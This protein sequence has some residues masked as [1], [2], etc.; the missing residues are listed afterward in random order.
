MSALALRIAPIQLLV[1]PAVA[2]SLL[3]VAA[4]LGP[5]AVVPLLGVLGLAVLL[6]APMQW[7]AIGLLGLALVADN[8]GERPADGRWRSPLLPLGE[9]LYDN[10]HKLTGIG[11]LRVS[12]L[13][14][15]IALLLLIVVM[16]KARRDAIDDPDNLGVLPNPM[17][18]AFAGFATTVLFLELYGLARGGDFKQSLWQARQ[19]FWLP[20]LGVL[21]GHA[22]KSARA[23]V[24]LLRTIMAVAW[25]R[26]LL[27]IYTSFAVFRPAGITV[28]YVTTHSDTI[29]AVVAILAGLSI[30]VE[31]FTPGHLVLNL[32]LQPV[33][34]MGLVVNDR[35][36]AFVGLG[37]G[38]LSLIGL[39]PQVL[40]RWLKRSLVV[41]VPAALVYVGVGWNSSA[42]VFKPVQALKSV[43]DESDAS[44]QTRD[45][46]NYNLTLT[47]KRSPILGSGFGHEY[48]EF[49]QAYRVDEVFAQYRFIAHNSVL[50]LLSL[51]GFAGFTML[52]AVFPVAVLVARRVLKASTSAVDRTTAYSAVM[53]VMCFVIQAWADMGLQSWMGVLVLTSLTGATGALWT[54]HTRAGM[55]AR[56]S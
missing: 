52:W 49:V 12:A 4:G 32:V 44:N 21:F 5:L 31:R 41:L 50:W 51:S 10:L 39:G 43:T 42:S 26:A 30:L 15:L 34:L 38:V 56:L 35:R 7:T 19:L 13:E 28:E 40:R 24:A 54:A 33:L 2:V 27:G 14:L 53:A 29:L 48:Y 45:I 17:K 1:W 46:E 55:P 6:A 25:V 47:L 18:H 8:P 16:R 3:M 11:A 22:F 20:M 36:V 9:L 37:A 23:R